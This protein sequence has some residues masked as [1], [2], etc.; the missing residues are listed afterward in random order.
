[1]V[2]SAERPTRGET[3]E[4]IALDLLAVV[5]GAGAAFLFTELLANHVKPGR[6]GLL[7]FLTIFVAFVGVGYWRSWRACLL[8]VLFGASF[9][10]MTVWDI[11]PA[12]LAGFLPPLALAASGLVGALV[13]AGLGALASRWERREDPAVLAARR[14]REGFVAMACGVAFALAPF[15]V[16]VVLQLKGDEGIVIGFMMFATWPIALLLLVLGLVMLG[17]R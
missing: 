12:E 8:A 9:V 14:R 10:T 7:R 11:R 4:N 13:G 1:M 2:G 3:V 16:G 6:V 15:V 17:R 5:A